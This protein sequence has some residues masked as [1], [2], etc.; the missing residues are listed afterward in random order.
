MTD[1][2]REDRFFQK[3]QECHFAVDLSEGTE[4]Y[5]LALGSANHELANLPPD[6]IIV[7]AYIHVKTAS[8]AVTS[9]VATLGTSSG[10]T[11]ILSAANLKTAGEQGT[12]AGQTDTG[13]GVTL[14]LG[15]TVTG[16]QTAVGK[17]VV[18]V[19]YLE[20]NKNT[21]DYTRI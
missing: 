15:V 2:R 19:E 11:E 17:Y 9:N 13:T 10:G 16:A 4:S 20:Y 5:E 1:M 3:K 8:D 6:A 14:F 21:G 7:D 12:F 18:V